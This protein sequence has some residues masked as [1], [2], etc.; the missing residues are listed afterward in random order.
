MLSVMVED[1]GALGSTAGPTARSAVLTRPFVTL[2]FAIL[3]GFSQY[4]LLQPLVPLL[5]VD[6]GGDAALVGVMALAFGIPSILIRPVLGRFVDLHGDSVMVMIGTAILGAGAALY[7]IPALIGI[8][9]GRVVQ[10]TGWAAL[11]TGGY[12]LLARMAPPDRRGEASGYYAV[13]PAVA[14]LVMPGLGILLYSATGAW[15]PL[16]FAVIATVAGLLVMAT[17]PIPRAPALTTDKVKVSWRGLTESSAFLPMALEAVNAATQSIFTFFMPVI[18]LGLS[19][20]VEAL[21]LYYPAYGLTMV[22]GRLLTPRVSDRVGRSPVLIAGVALALATLVIGAS[23]SSMFVLAFAGC[24]A[25]FSGALLT[26]TLSA[27]TIDRA[28]PGRIG[29]A[30]ATYSLG[31]QIGL[32]IG[33]ALWGFLIASLGVRSPFVAAAALQVLVIVFLAM[34]HD[35]AVASSV[36]NRD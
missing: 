12:S 25:A 5:V 24:L 11:N 1:H 34:R 30:V 15:L 8:A 31:Y 35:T 32:G 20:P 3:L 22:V 21:T 33:G 2:W 23:A 14:Q 13:A 7:A 18:V 10:G 26:P 9:I 27:L 4:H 36:D 19:L 28:S 29:A 6:L 17:G 16:M